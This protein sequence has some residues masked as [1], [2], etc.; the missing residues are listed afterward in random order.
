MLSLIRRAKDS[1][2]RILLALAVKRVFAQAFVPY[3]SL[4]P[5]IPARLSSSASARQ[6]VS[7]LSSLC[8]RLPI[9]LAE[10]F[11]FSLLSQ[12]SISL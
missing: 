9:Q 3:G 6:M 10:L 8:Q 5:A 1:F 11:F 2:L 12:T 7:S 4:L